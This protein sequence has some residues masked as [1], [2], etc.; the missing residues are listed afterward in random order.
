MS[1]PLQTHHKRF[2]EICSLKSLQTFP[3][4]FFEFTIFR[5]NK[6]DTNLQTDTTIYFDKKKYIFVVVSTP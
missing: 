5:Q 2:D 1:S 6:K 3:D 4:N